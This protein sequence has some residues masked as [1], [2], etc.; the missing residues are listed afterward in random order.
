MDRPVRM[1]FLIRFLTNAAALWV[2]VKIV[3]GI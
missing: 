2:A 1:R 3:P